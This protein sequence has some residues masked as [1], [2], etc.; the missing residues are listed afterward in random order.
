MW[1]A[2]WK[3]RNDGDW[4]T[5]QTTWLQ[6]LRSLLHAAHGRRSGKLRN[7]DVESSVLCMLP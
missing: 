5:G 2:E 4:S 3:L 6:V 1:N 7:V